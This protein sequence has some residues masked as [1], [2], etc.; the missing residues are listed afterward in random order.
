MYRMLV[1]ALLFILLPFS[2]FAQGTK[3]DYERAMSL[4]KRTDGKVLMRAVK[5]NWQPDGDTFWYK[6]ETGGGGWEF[7]FVDCAKG[8]RAPAFDHAKLAAALKHPDPAKL[9]V[10]ALKVNGTE[11]WVRFRFEGKRW[12]F[13]NDTGV[14]R[15]VPDDIDPEAVAE[16]LKPRPSREDG[17]TDTHITFVNKS[18]GDAVLWWIDS[19]GGRKTY[20]TLKPGETYKQHTF[21]GHVW[22]VESPGGVP[23]GV[24]EGRAKEIEAVIPEPKAEAVK[25]EE[26]RPKPPQPQQ[27]PQQWKAFTRDANF[28]LKHRETGEEVQLSR[29]GTKDDPYLDRAYFSPDGKFVVAVQERPE[30][31]YTVYF[32]ESSP[33]DQLQP[34]LHKQQY[35]KP[36]DRIAEPKLRLF[37]IAVRKPVAVKN[38]L[39]PKPWSLGEFRWQA[40]S[41]EF[42]FLYNERGHQVLRWVALKPTGE[43]RTFVEEKSATFVDYSQKTWSRWLDKTS[44]FLWASE[45]D[46]WNHLYRFDAK[47]GALKNR[48]TSGEWN[49][50]SVIRVD[51]EKQQL[52]LR[53]MG[54]HAGQDPYFFHIARVNFDG[55]GFTVITGGDGTRS[56][57]RRGGDLTLSPNGRWLV[58]T[59]SRVDLPPVTEVRDTTTGKLSCMLEK[60]EATAQIAAGWTM[61]ERFVAKGRDG[62]TDIHGIII[63]P[64]NFD[65]AKKYPV[66]EE[67]YA[68][69]HGFF[70]PK[71][72]GRQTRQHMMAELGFIVVQLDGMGTNWRG[73]KFH[74]VAWRNIKD[75]GFPDR[76]AWMKAAAKTRPWMD[77]TR[78]G[79]YGGSAGGQNTLSGLLH[80]GDFYKVGVAD[81]GCHDNRMD[82]IW[83]NEAWLGEVGPWYA[84]NSNVVHAHKLTGKLLLVVGEV[85]T[86]VDPASTMQVANA[87]VKADKDFDLLVMPS[88]NHGAAETPYASRRRMDFFVRH[89]LNVEP[90]SP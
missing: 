19:S 29:D 53:V 4:A 44:D 37:D 79:I 16:S 86:N 88:T 38:D 14:L 32:V 26:P 87:L 70:A 48:I 40:D 45:R 58:D 55:S 11:Q 68:G 10:E 71:E 2:T 49:V 84:E 22:F 85:D 90:R 23:L 21:E 36:G 7:V 76:I 63:R 57:G 9:P 35:L 13:A 8:T 12:H 61:P 52:W 1:R 30:Q 78:V 89:L 43:A 5:P 66:I 60:A 64:S 73:K 3:A 81:C 56:G 46:G 59:Y 65:P 67:I 72:W 54:F 47:T 31:E 18:G 50:S 41:S 20:N 39:F 80:F 33:K 28:W 6:V 69:P 75:A 34:K 17:G 83:W 82:K 24:F 15:E 27:P 25:K 42:V 77:L 74:D 62:T 51:E